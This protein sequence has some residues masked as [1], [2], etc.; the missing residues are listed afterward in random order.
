MP[1]D[2]NKI[3]SFNI[4]NAAKYSVANA[5]ILKAN[6]I[7]HYGD[8]T[9]SCFQPVKDFIK[10][11]Y[12]L[13][14]NRRCAYC[15]KRLNADG[16]FNHIDHIIPKSHHKQWMFNPK[17]L[18]ITCEVCN[19]LKNDHDTLTIGYSK[20]KFPRTIAG[21]TIFNPHF[22]KWENCFE[23]ED[24]MFIKGRNKRGEETI[25]IC[26]LHQY[27]FSVQFSEESEVIP[28]SAIK[29]ATLRQ[30]AFT[31]GSIEYESASKV[32]DYYKRLI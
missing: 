19:P 30:R 27:Q 14:Q 2:L 10:S 18:T 20:K 31:K 26:K 24:G 12:Y 6:P 13:P 1:K 15:R 3:Y 5:A 32:I 21:F 11:K 8:W 17:N 16:Y 23:I 9:K 25:K 4:R 22:D 29:R 28:K 7:K